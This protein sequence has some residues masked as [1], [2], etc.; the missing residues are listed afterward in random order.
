MEWLNYHHLLYFWTVA[1][2]GSVVK[3]SE[4]LRLAQPTISA[5]IHQ[6]E[7]ALGGKL[8]N[9][10]GRGLVLTELGQVTY[11]YAEEIFGLGRELQSVIQGRGA[12]RASKFEVG[13]ADVFPK[14]LAYRVLA[15]VFSLEPAVR[16][17]C[18]EDHTETLLEKLATHQLD[19]ILSDAPVS[20]GIRVKAYNHLL[21]TSQVA[22]FGTAP[23]VKQYRNG[24]LDGAPFLF[25][26][27]GASLRRSLDQWFDARGIAPRVVGEFKDSALL[28]AFGQAGAGLFAAPV[29]VGNE[30]SET[31]GVKM[32][33]EMEG[34]AERFYAISVERRLKHPAVLAVTQ[35]AREGIFG[36]SEESA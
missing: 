18:T 3:A 34:V 7:D 35:A 31:Y 5:Q 32:F 11:R 8:F 24:S 20:P 23:L 1:K 36:K 21:G 4:R 33:M 25:P 13:V 28:K 2:E 6:L 10:A 29:A 15:P 12:G 22:L 19:L 17:I 14:L 16:L 9:R 30:I 27:A 26:A